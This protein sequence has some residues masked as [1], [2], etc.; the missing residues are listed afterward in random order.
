MAV[1][2]TG[3]GNNF[4]SSILPLVGML[5]PGAGPWVAGAMVANN[6]LGGGNSSLG[7]IVGNLFGGKPN[8]MPSDNL[9]KMDK[10]PAPNPDSTP[11]GTPAT[12]NPFGGKVAA[13]VPNPAL[14]VQDMAGA[15]GVSPDMIVANLIGTA[16]DERNNRYYPNWH[17]SA[18]GHGGLMR[19]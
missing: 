16:P 6:L 5:V 19:R 7:S 18:F 3:G 4:F 12:A 14:T 13:P 1:H 9:V 10:T 17:R 11:I 15:A 8:A 2:Y